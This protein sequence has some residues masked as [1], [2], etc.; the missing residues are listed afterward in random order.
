M[1]NLITW[2]GA[3]TSVQYLT[4]SGRSYR[5]AKSIEK[6]DLLNFNLNGKIAS[7][8]K[9]NTMPLINETDEVEAT[10]VFNERSGGLEVVVLKNRTLN[11][12]WKFS[13][14]RAMFRI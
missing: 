4:S 5:L 13:R 1:T 9:D 10:G 6:A 8:M 7:L 12:E 2:Q 3:A 11:I 14:A